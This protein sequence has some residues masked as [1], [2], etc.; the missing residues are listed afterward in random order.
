[1]ALLDALVAEGRFANRSDALRAGLGRL[2]ADER[3]RQIDAA[4]ARGYGE[5][6][7]EE[8]VGEAGLAGLTAFDAANRGEPL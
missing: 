7:Q 5:H 8:W 1:M 4:Y 3:E 6:P 2:A